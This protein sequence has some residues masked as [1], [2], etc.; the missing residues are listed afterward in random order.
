MKIILGQAL[1]NQILLAIALQLNNP[2]FFKISTYFYNQDIERID[3]GFIKSKWK[4]DLEV[5]S[6]CT[7]SDQTSKLPNIIT[8]VFNIQN[9]MLYNFLFHKPRIYGIFGI[10]NLT[11]PINTKKPRCYIGAFCFWPSR[12]DYYLLPV[13]FCSSA[14][15][16]ISRILRWNLFSFL[17][18]CL[19]S[20]IWACILSSSRIKFLMTSMIPM[21]IRFDTK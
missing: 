3:L 11:K 16:I 19:F 12:P 4:L 18:F 7:P 6:W 14:C 13:F 20:W 21:V 8:G 15:S 5:F 2:N 9:P 10:P 17:G 1:R